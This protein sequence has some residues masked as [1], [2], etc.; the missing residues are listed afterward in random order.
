MGLVSSQEDISHVQGGHRGDGSWQRLENPPD[1]RG[2]EALEAGFRAAAHSSAQASNTHSNRLPT[3]RGWMRQS[4][5]APSLRAPLLSEQTKAP[6][7]FISKSLRGCPRAF[8]WRF[9]LWC[10]LPAALGACCLRSVGAGPCGSVGVFAA[11]QLFPSA[12]GRAIICSTPGGTAFQNE[13][14]APDSRGRGAT[15]R[16]RPLK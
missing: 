6:E 11:G 5:Q 12:G 13:C 4:L 10:R 1:C 14:T 15:S 9:S 7:E 3:V 16:T 2:G 8:A